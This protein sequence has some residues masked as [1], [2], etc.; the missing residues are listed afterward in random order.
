MESWEQRC[1]SLP[2]ICEAI[3]FVSLLIFL[4]LVLSWLDAGPSKENGRRHSFAE[5]PCHVNRRNTMV[6]PGHLYMPEGVGGGPLA[7]K[8]V[9]LGHLCMPRKGL[10]PAI[11]S[12]LQLLQALAFNSICSRTYFLYSHAN[13]CKLSTLLGNLLRLNVCIYVH[14]I[15]HIHCIPSI[16]D[17]HHMH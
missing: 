10:A 4:H 8:H 7:S 13:T 2:R 1:G 14:R 5:H 9:N 3:F 11:P 15:P 16:N 17:L 12:P 6:P